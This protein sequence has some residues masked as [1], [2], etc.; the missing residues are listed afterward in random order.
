MKIKKYLKE[1][2]EKQLE[3]VLQTL[4]N[5]VDKGGKLAHK[6]FSQYLA[7]IGFKPQADTMTVKEALDTLED[8]NYHTEYSILEALMKGNKKDADILTMIATEH[9]K[10][11]SMPYDLASLRSYISDRKRFEQNVKRGIAIVGGPINY[12]E[13]VL[14][15]MDKKDAEK[16]VDLYA[17]RMNQ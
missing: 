16:F 8:W 2:S 14:K 1:A 5:W 9:K 6:G 7:K 11:G 3:V 17:E 13:K 4:A 15:K 10:I 12:A